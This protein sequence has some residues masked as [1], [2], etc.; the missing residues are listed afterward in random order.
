MQRTILVTE[1]RHKDAPL[2]TKVLFGRF[3]PVT[4]SR[5]G[6]IIERQYKQMYTMSD[7][8]FAAHGNKKGDKIL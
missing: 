6:W 4:I 8:E 7:A 3:D 5:E 2:R 1:L